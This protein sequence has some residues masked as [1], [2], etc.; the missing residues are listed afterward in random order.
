[1][2]NTNFN[3][4]SKYFIINSFRKLFNKIQYLFFFQF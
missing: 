2:S 4:C 3:W 1:M